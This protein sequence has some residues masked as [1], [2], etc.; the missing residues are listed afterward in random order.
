MKKAPEQSLIIRIR[1]YNLF[2]QT[3]EKFNSL[4]F[5]ASLSYDNITYPF[6]YNTNMSVL[7]PSSL[8]SGG[9]I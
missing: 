2:S 9:V 8:S 3:I 6:P 7:L 1:H 4:N 5:E